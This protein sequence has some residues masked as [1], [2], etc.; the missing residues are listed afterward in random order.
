MTSRIL[1]LDADRLGALRGR[2]LTESVAASAGR[3]IVAEVCAERTLADGV[4]NMELAAAF[5]ADILVVNHVERVWGGD[6]W[7]LPVLGEYPDLSA[8]AR[9]VGRP[10]GV[11]LEPGGVPGPRRATTW[12][13]QR[14]MDQGVAMICLTANPSTRCSYA[15]LADVTAKLRATLGSGVALWSGKMHHAGVRES[16]SPANL[17]MLTDAGADGVLLP[18][19]GTVPGV[20][21]EEA[22][23]AVRAV[24]EAGAVVMGTV[25]TSQEGAH[26]SIAVPLALA[27]KEAGVDAHHLGNAF[28]GGMA[29]PELLYAYAVA[30]RGRRH[31][32][33]RMARRGRS[34]G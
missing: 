27:A 22:A 9:R 1:D 15:D 18:L 12:N 11:N 8:L 31:T 17:R 19:P 28:M 6:E 21:A 34:A 32:W 14:L 10:V 24:H 33:H 5:G 4:H 3:A 29:D 13:A 2:A 30:V 20:T 26:R 23:E 25:G 7:C 16:P